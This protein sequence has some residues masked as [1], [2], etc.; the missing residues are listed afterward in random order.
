M[1]TDG[2]GAC[3]INDQPNWLPAAGVNSLLR[4]AADVPSRA[5]GSLGERLRGCRPRVPDAPPVGRRDWVQDPDKKDEET[6]FIQ[7]KQLGT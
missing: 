1:L 5:H 7:P 4:N 2:S 3:A 6:T